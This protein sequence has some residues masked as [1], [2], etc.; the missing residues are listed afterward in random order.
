M[1]GTEYA[2]VTDQTARAVPVL[3]SRMDRAVIA[4]VRVGV[5]L[6][7]LQNVGWKRSG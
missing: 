4:L 7:W 6:L 2:A 5:G 1:A 3:S